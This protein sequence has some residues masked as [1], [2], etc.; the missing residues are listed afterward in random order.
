MIIKFFKKIEYND[1][2]INRKNITKICKQ[3]KNNEILN[4]LWIV[5]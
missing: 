3:N 2:L 1:V 5:V 4:N